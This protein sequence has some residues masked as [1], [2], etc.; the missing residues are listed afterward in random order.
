[1]QLGYF[2]QAAG[3]PARARHYYEL[4]LRSPK[5]EYK[6]STDAKAKVALRTLK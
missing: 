5:H 1:L 4:V 6:N 2:A 3:Q